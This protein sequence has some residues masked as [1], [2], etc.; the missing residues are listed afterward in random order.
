MEFW[1]IDRQMGGIIENIF[2]APRGGAGM[3]SADEAEAVAEAGLRGDR[4]CLRT[5]HWSRVDE[6]QVT[7]IEGEDLDGI[8]EKTG[9]A[10]HEGQHRRNLV[11]RG[12]HLNELAGRRFRVGEAVLEFE[13]ARPPCRHVE[14]LSE[15]GMAR[16]LLG[17]GGVCARVVSSG[18]IRVNDAIEVIEN[19]EESSESPALARQ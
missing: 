8:H 7:L 14:C 12:L 18:R 11:T 16:A 9:I 13:R 19:A 15:A 17:R 6:C 5:G 1:L 2:I 3:L 10:V 4:Y